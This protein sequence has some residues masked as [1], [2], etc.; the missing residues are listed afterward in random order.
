MASRLIYNLV[1]EMA[2][3]EGKDAVRFTH[4]RWSNIFSENAGKHLTALLRYLNIKMDMMDFYTLYNNQAFDP[5]VNRR[6][7]REEWWS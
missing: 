3:S 7:F 2:E 6:R 1:R 5:H 4:L